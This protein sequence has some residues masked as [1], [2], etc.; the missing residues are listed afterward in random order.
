MSNMRDPF[1]DL[2]YELTA[3][4]L[5]NLEL[6]DLLRI[7][8]VNRAFRDTVLNSTELDYQLH[9][10]IAGIIDNPHSSLPLSDRLDALKRSEKAWGA[11]DVQR[12]R[13]IALHHQP[14]G[15][16]DLSAGSYICTA[17]E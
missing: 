15:L 8:Q 3:S 10:Y 4:I 16:Y 7:Q 9:A 6:H 17:A 11:F 14:S 5:L 1:I 12:R 2:P 13:K